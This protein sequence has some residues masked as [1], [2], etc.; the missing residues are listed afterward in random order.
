MAG[1]RDSG[2]A[3]GT[4]R[5]TQPLGPDRGPPGKSIR[6][7]SMWGPKPGVKEQRRDSGFG[8][9]KTVSSQHCHFK[10]LNLQKKK[11]KKN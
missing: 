6:K 3:G 10:E 11:K 9:E 5:R 1:D 4:D 7:C 8:V 2:E